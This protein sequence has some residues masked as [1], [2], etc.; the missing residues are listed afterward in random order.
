MYSGVLRD[1]A[2]RAAKLREREEALKESRE[3]QRLY[4]S[5]QHVQQQRR[6]QYAQEQLCAGTCAAAAQAQ[7]H[8]ED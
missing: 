8:K 5:V 2:R 6:R 1:D 3:K 4:E 7:E